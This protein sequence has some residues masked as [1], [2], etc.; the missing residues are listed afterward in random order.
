MTTLSPGQLLTFPARPLVLA[1]RTASDLAAVRRVRETVFGDEQQMMDS[2]A[3]DPD[4][5][6]SLHALALLTLDG[7]QV[8]VSTGRLTPDYGEGGEAL[9][10]WVATLPAYRGRGIG[11]AVIRFLLRSADSTRVP[12]V[13]LSAQAHAIDFYERLGFVTFGRRYTI[14]GIEHQWMARHRPPG[15]P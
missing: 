11:S 9:I 3:T 7:E 1:A 14:R 8:P 13:V 5:A 12:L 15:A 2:T 6:R 10:A 4:D